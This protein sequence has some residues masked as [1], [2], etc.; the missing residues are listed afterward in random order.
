[1]KE[2]GKESLIS[3]LKESPFYSMLPVEEKRILIKSLLTDNPSL[4]DEKKEEDMDI[5][6]YECGWQVGQPE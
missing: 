6:G 5:I 3:I 4:F 2:D 1:M